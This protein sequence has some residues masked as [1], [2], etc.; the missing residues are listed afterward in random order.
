MHVELC[1]SLQ[2]KFVLAERVGKAKAAHASEEGV[3]W[4][5]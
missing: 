3:C 5:Q 4:V 1:W 2:G